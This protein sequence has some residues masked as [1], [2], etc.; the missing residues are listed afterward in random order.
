LQVQAI[1]D[2]Y[3]EKDDDEVAKL[4]PSFQAQS[5][6][7]FH[8]AHSSGNFFKPRRYIMKCFPCILDHCA[9]KSQEEMDSFA[10]PRRLV[11]EVG[12]GSGSSCIPILKH[13]SEN[14]TLLACDSSAVAVEV[15]KSVIESLPD[16]APRASSNFGVFVSDPSLD[17]DETHSTFAQDVKD[18]HMQLLKESTTNNNHIIGLA[19]VV[20]MV[21]V[22]SAVPPKR[23]HRFMK[24][25][26]G[27]TKHGGKVCFRD[28]ALY[29]L[30]MMRL[31]QVGNSPRLYERGDGTLSR[32]FDLETV[33][34]IFEEVG[35]V[36]EELRYA[37]VFND[38]RKT[39]ERLKRAFVH[40]V[41]RKA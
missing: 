38:N 26:Y 34:V 1:P 37:T 18:A 7:G 21:F 5:W 15:C 32:F 8:S 9:L 11:L 25:I 23:V 6:D 39:G 16:D 3:D 29:D 33:K 17:S 40:A 10:L 19:D 31:K 4:Q 41:F 20:L 28:Y 2:E 30:P 12:C 36:E 13:C 14:T 24:Q 22:L 35:F 27:A